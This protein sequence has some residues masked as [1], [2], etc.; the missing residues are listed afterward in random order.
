MENN[1]T[2]DPFASEL[3]RQATTVSKAYGYD[4]LVEQAK[5][6]KETIRLLI[7]LGELEDLTFVGSTDTALFQAL[8]KKAKLLSI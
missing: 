8:V 3:F 2:T 1:T 7:E 5:E 4:I 6:L